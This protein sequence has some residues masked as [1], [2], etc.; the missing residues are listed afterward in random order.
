M[1]GWKDRNYSVLSP[2]SLSLWR[3]LGRGFLFLLLCSCEHKDLCYHHPHQVTIRVEFDWRNAPEANPEGMCV[4]FYPEEGGMPQRF[5]FLGANGGEINIAGGKYHLLC[6]NNDTKAIQFRGVD[7]FYTHEGFTR[8]GSVLEP[9]YGSSYFSRNTPQARGS[10][11]ER[12]VICPDMLWGC[13]ALDID[14][15]ESGVFYTCVPEKEKDE[16]VSVENREQVITLYP[17]EQV[18]HYSYEIRNVNNLRGASQMCAT[19]SGMAGTQLMANEEL[20][21]ECLT[22]PFEAHPNQETAQITGEFLTF[23]HHTENSSPHNL[24]LYVI[25]RN[26][27]K[28]YYTF[29]VTHQVHT[30]PNPRRVHL[31]IEELTLPDNITDEGEGF[32]VEVDDWET[33]HVDLPM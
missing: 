6:Y 4:F 7:R 5:D 21:S 1:M 28:Y 32:E 20:G 27:Q 2:T 26:G 13:T 16:L 17:C 10:E 33:V 12:V 14:I 9:I 11:E 22:L 8:E 25:F 15:T 31:I 3:G 18:C 29:D 19:L 30:A 23:G 24:V